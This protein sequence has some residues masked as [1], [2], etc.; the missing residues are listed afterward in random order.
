MNEFIFIFLL[1]CIKSWITYNRKYFSSILD[2]YSYMVVMNIYILITILLFGLYMYTPDQI[3]RKIKSISLLHHLRFF[4]V[5]ICI[6]CVIYMN[7]YLYKKFSMS[8]VV[9]Y[10]TILYLLL[11]TMIAV[12]YLRE[13]IS[14]LHITAMIF[15][16]IGLFCLSKST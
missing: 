7:V 9:S 6:V 16:I 5:S 12:F 10:T 15:F 4:I 3:V 1:S 14:T 2:T 13:H 8:F 11:T